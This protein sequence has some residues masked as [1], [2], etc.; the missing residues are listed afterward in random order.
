M[1]GRTAKVTPA[2]AWTAFDPLPYVLA[3]AAASMAGV[4]SD[5]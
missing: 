5:I 4:D 2:R 3:S 1:P